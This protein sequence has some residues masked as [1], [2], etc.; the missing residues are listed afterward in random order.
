MKKILFFLLPVM[1]LL[2]FCGCKVFR[3]AF[4]RPS[5][6]RAENRSGESRPSASRDPVMDMFKIKNKPDYLQDKELSS[7]ERALLKE[8]M[9]TGDSEALVK[10]IRSDYD[11]QRKRR[12]DWVFSR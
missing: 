11:A 3:Q 2:F 1:I 6:R 9:H 4:S 7:Y 10:S 8:Q 5:G 12:H